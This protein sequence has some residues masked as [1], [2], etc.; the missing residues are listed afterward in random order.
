MSGGT[1]YIYDIDGRFQSRLNPEMVIALPVKRK[2]D[3]AE[4][5]ALI[6]AQLEKTGSPRA[7]EILADWDGMLPKLVR[8]IA[9][10]KYDLEKAEEEHEAAVAVK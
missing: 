3:K 10:E 4:L 7:Q 2:H 6:E 1:A 9:K 8:V 5:K